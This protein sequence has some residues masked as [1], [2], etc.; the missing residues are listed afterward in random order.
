MDSFFIILYPIN[1][2]ECSYNSQ[3]GLMVERKLFPPLSNKVRDNATGDKIKATPFYPFYTHG[4]GVTRL[5][6]IIRTFKRALSLC[7]VTYPYIH[8]Y[9]N[10]PVISVQVAVAHIQ[11][12]L[13]PTLEVSI[14]A[15]GPL[16]PE[17]TTATLVILFYLDR[18]SM[19]SSE[20]GPYHLCLSGLGP[21]FHLPRHVHR[22]FFHSLVPDP[23]LILLH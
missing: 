4:L 19:P 15:W 16:M 22:G 1:S 17:V 18:A 21:I 10:F 12:F 11:R 7:Y 23:R 20:F 9:I 13:H 6:L 14:R 2:N 5:M 8:L 3:N